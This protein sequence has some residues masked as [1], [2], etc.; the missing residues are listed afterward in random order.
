MKIAESAVLPFEALA[1]PEDM[2]KNSRR[3]DCTM[4]YSKFTAFKRR[5]HCRVCGEIMCSTCFV[6]RRAKIPMVGLITIKVCT[7]C[8]NGKA[9]AH[10][11]MRE[12][13]PFPAE[14]P[15]QEAPSK[16]VDVKQP[17]YKSASFSGGGSSYTSPAFTTG[18]YPT[19]PSTLDLD[20]GSLNL[21]NRM[22]EGFRDVSELQAQW[23]NTG[24][25]RDLQHL[26]D[27]PRYA[28]WLVSH[29]SLG[30]LVAKRLLRGPVSSRTAEQFFDEIE[31][32]GHVQHPRIVE[33]LG[34]ARVNEKK[35]RVQA[36]YEFMPHGDLRTYLTLTARER[37]N[38]HERDRQKLAVALDIAEALVHLHS[39]DPPIIH[40]RLHSG[41]VLLTDDLRAKLSGFSGSSWALEDKKPGFR[42]WLAP[43]LLSDGGEVGLQS[44]IYAFGVLLSELDTHQVPYSD[45]L[46]PEGAPL[47]ES[48]LKSLVAD[49]ELQPTM[50]QDCPP[51][52]RQL[53]MECLAY[54][55]SKRPTA[56]EVSV[57]L[58][59][60]L[61]S[62]GLDE[63]HEHKEVKV[64]W[65]PTAGHA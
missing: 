32:M 59:T 8:A 14:L 55:P 39:F 65:A 49:G 17:V 44:D 4:C 11:D 10:E 64:L 18:S 61:R 3:P 21:E 58:R 38:R 29:R 33:L 9:D 37:K 13:S 40:G 50:S 41:K 6:K 1:K 36:V 62:H 53:A 7:S 47:P 28:L 48:E 51:Q 25:L 19:N 26:R 57:R 35:N 56:L 24:D 63:T 52:L 16:Y 31:L 46:T 42:S 15:T 60:F 30:R 20:I 45:C 5:H 12:P 54:K 27:G 34:V 2:V 23:L 43:E 22:S